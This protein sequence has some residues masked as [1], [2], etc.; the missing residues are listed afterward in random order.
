[1]V[2]SFIR[3]HN[4]AMRGLNSIRKFE[5]DNFNVCS[6]FSFWDKRGICNSSRAGEPFVQAV[7]RTRTVEDCWRCREIGAISSQLCRVSR[8][9]ERA[10]SRWPVLTSVFMSLPNAHYFYNQAKRKKDRTEK[11]RKPRDKTSFF[12][13]DQILSGHFYCRKFF[14]DNK[15]CFPFFKWSSYPSQAPP[16]WI[17]RSCFSIFLPLLSIA[18]CLLILHGERKTC[19]DLHWCVLGRKNL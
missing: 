19:P 13:R 16:A 18:C 10:R 12:I 8:L 4:L 2:Y 17:T 14:L 1:M 11:T 15:P 5:M 3:F 7:T 6:F 9:A